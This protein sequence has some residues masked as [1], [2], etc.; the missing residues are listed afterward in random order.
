ML[1]RK[2]IV[3]DPSVRA[4]VHAIDQLGSEK[5]KVLDDLGKRIENEIN[6]LVRSIE[7]NFSCIYSL[8]FISDKLAIL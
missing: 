1:Y 3:K 7:K 2:R 5:K 8:I 6:V 4:Q